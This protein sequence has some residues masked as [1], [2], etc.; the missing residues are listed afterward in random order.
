[1]D[2]FWTGQIRSFG[3]VNKRGI[4]ALTFLDRSTLS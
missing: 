1:M 4:E 2:M 3:E